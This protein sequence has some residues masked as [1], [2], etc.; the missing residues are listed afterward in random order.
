MCLTS[1]SSLFLLQTII[2]S[3]LQNLRSYISNVS[4]NF[5]N[6]TF[7]AYRNI[8]HDLVLAFAQISHFAKRILIKRNSGLIYIQLL[9]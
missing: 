3:D 8:C 2:L 6:S 1:K 9:Q 4:E 7:A 5:K